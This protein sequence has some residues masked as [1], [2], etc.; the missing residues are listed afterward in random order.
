MRV[1]CCTSS[2]LL[3]TGWLG[4]PP[5]QQMWRFG[6]V[7]RM[8]ISQHIMEV[9]T[10]YA[11]T[12][13]YPLLLQAGLVWATRDIFVGERLALA[14][15]PLDADGSHRAAAPLLQGDAENKATAGKARGPVLHITCTA[16]GVEAAPVHEEAVPA[17]A[18]VPLYR[19][20]L[21]HPTKLVA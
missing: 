18:L 3:L 19:L 7:I 9:V 8:R 2:T 20:D 15:A 11:Q 5:R 17:A 16:E 14:G 4:L 1:G 6:C 12:H 21:V 10:Y 13:A